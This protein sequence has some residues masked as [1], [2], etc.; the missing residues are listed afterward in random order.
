MS[1]LLL[2]KLDAAA[3]RRVR[4]TKRSLRTALFKLISEKE[5]NHITVKEITALADVNRSTFYLYYTDVYNMY[6]SIQDEIY[7]IFAKEIIPFESTFT[8]PDDFVQYCARFLK[9][10]KQNIETCKFIFRNETNNKIAKR[11]KDTII[12]AVPDSHKSFPPNDPRH[13]LTT[14]V[15]YGI[16]FTI[17]EW[18]ESGM[19]CPEED[20]ALF[21]AYT[22][23]YGSRIQKDGKFCKNYKLYKEKGTEKQ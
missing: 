22:Y 11:I 8:E 9:F 1:E 14:Y 20:M 13:F 10:C 16:T 19:E 21:L 4:K 15:I 2:D 3:D 12:E 7:R 5:I 18:V 6:E 23:V 17:I